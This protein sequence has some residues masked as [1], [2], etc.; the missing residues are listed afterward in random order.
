MVDRYNVR[1]TRPALADLA[2][3]GDYHAQ[4]RGPDEADALVDRLSE[5][6]AGLDRSPL[7][8]PVPKELRHTGRTD[9]RQ[10]MLGRHRIFYLVGGDEV[11][12]FMFADGRRDIEALLDIRLLAPD[13]PA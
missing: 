6:I 13:P 10:T 1:L 2:E 4:L 3:I 5:R 8:G 7:R 11:A 12:V 9:V